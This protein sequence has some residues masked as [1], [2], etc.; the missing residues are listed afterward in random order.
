MWIAVATTV[1]MQ[2][3]TPP[4][5]SMAKAIVTRTA[6]ISIIGKNSLSKKRCE[7]SAGSSWV[8]K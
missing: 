2:A 6:P 7:G 3:I 4:S 8:K 5:G 1:T